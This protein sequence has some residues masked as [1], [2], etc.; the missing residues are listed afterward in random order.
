MPLIRKLRSFLAEQMQPKY[1]PNAYLEDGN[2]PETTL[3]S[4]QAGCPERTSE[5][6]SEASYP[7]PYEED[8]DDEDDDSEPDHDEKRENAELLNQALEF[9]THPPPYN[10]STKKLALPVVIPRDGNGMGVPFTRCFAPIL[11]DHGVSQKDFIEFIDNLNTVSAPNGALQV[12]SF[13]GKLASFAPSAIAKGVGTAVQIGAQVGSGAMSAKIRKEF[14]DRANKAYFRPRS[15]WVHV[16]GTKDLTNLLGLPPNQP[17]LPPINPQQSTL[18]IQQRRL[19]ALSGRIASLT[20]DVPPP[21]KS[22]SVLV[23]LSHGITQ[24]KLAK[25]ERRMLK[26]RERAQRRAQRR[27]NNGKT[28]REQDSAQQLTWLYIQS[29]DICN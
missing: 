22:S 13:A 25:S 5:W 12:A 7:P 24:R 18:T 6:S 21:N 15:L 16:V 9:T 19:A 14:M 2:E 8:Y 10:I 3:S 17:L 27:G 4:R 29:I 28:D 1:D 20:F 26:S 23:N 11:L